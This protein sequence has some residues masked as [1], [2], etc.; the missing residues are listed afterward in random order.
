MN[1]KDSDLTLPWDEPE[2]TSDLRAALSRNLVD[3]NTTYSKPRRSSILKLPSSNQENVTERIA[4]QVNKYH[5]ISYGTQL[6]IKFIL[7]LTF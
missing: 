6:A 4:L 5:T 7:I 1:F 3:K 2:R